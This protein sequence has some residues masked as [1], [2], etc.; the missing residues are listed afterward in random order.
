[1]AGF[2]ANKV[3]KQRAS[4]KKNKEGDEEGKTRD[5]KVSMLYI[6][7]RI[8]EVKHLVSL[9]QLNCLFFTDPY[10]TTKLG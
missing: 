4:M 6:K 9:I 5:I 1:M 8:T 3:R 7:V 2:V 10:R